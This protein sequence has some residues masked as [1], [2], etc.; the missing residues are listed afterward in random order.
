MLSSIS[1]Y[2]AA[3]AALRERLL[4]L[5]EEEFAE[6]FSQIGWEPVGET[7]EEQVDH[8]LTNA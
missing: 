7:V 6:Y 2:E 3:K 5:S 1:E 8:Y 4:V